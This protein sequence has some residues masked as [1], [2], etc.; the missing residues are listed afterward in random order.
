M[1]TNCILQSQAEELKRAFRTGAISMEKLFSLPSSADRVLLFEKY[2]GDGAKMAVAKLEKAYMAKNQ[3]QAIRNWIFEETAGI[4]PLYANISLSQA[5][6]MSENLSINELKKLSPEKRIEEF[7]KYVSQKT[8]EGLNKKFEYLNTTGNLKI[9]EQKA[10]GTEALKQEGKLKGELAKLEA[11]NDMGVLNPKQLEKFMQSFVEVKLG[12]DINY[13][14]SKQ[15]SSL[16]DKQGDLFDKLKKSG[17]WTNFQDRLDYEIAVNKL[18]K[19]TQKLKGNPSAAEVG[20]D[21]IDIGRSNI[22]MTPYS[23]INSMLYQANPSI[24]K[25]LTKRITFATI[26]QEGSFMEKLKTKLEAG[27]FIDKEGYK[28]A[29]NQLKLGMAIYDKTGVD[30]SRSY[31]LNQGYSFFGE[32]EKTGAI[33]LS[34]FGRRAK[35]IKEQ[36]KEATGIKGKIASSIKGYAEIV[37]L[38][39]KWMAG[40]TDSLIANWTKATSVYLWS[41]EKARYEANT[42]TLPKGLT[43]EQRLK[44]LIKESYNPFSTD[45][46]AQ[47]IVSQAIGDAHYSNS[48]Q[49]DSMADWIVALRDK[50]GTKNL[51]I[52]KLITPFAK[53]T[54]TTIS[55]GF[56]TATPVGVIKELNNFIKAGRHIDRV[57]GIKQANKA[58]SNLIGF[59][60]LFATASLIA[61]FLD[62]DD[63]IPP[64]ALMSAKEYALAEAQGAK[65]GSI[66]RGG[67][68]IPVR[69][70]P[71]ISIP[72]GSIM[73]ARQAKSQGKSFLFNYF[74]G[75][76]SEILGMPVINEFTRLYKKAEYSMEAEDFVDYLDKQ[77]LNGSDVWNWTKIRLIPSMLSRDLYDAVLPTTKYNFLGEEVE[78]GRIFKDDKTNEVLLEFVELNKTN[79]MP[80]ISKPKNAKNVSDKKYAELCQNYAEKVKIK[81][82]EFDYKISSPE[83]KKTIIDAIRKAEILNEL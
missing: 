73:F 75:M 28:F 8:A 52:G 68:W 41:K 57:E 36:I 2:L 9:W 76:Y 44:Q 62:D 12:A 82:N 7:S 56:Q 1:P 53:I 33:P 65:P 81:I 49:P 43:E 61:L 21:L 3:K 29:W 55:K 5:K 24:E 30:I 70:L 17:D 11:I 67:K 66:R 42:N 25:A 31:T 37:A 69:Y 38:G 27:L 71:L 83:K 20:N 19:F 47:I 35:E 14:Q 64:Y 50:L 32:K 22:L 58:V 40:G 60:G 18:N 48:T 4:K 46:S 26:G 23:G 80:T 74:L 39:P 77:G 72:L 16:I 59:I 63:Y 79:N 6:N 78:K 13:E 45:E 51:K 34:E 15:L 10:F 54:S